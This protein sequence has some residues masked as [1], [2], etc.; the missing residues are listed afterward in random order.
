M[1]FLGAIL[2]GA[3]SGLV[4]GIMGGG[5]SKPGGSNVYSPAGLNA[6]DTGWQNM[7]SQQQNNAL[8]TQAVTNPLYNQTLAALTGYQFTPGQPQPIMQQGGNPLVNPT[9]P[10]SK[11]FAPQLSE[12]EGGWDNTMLNQQPGMQAGQ[13]AMQQ[14][15]AMQPVG[16]TWSQTGGGINY[17]PWL[18]SAQQAGQQYQGVA[19]LAGKQ[20]G[21]YGQQAGLA[22]RQ[23]QGLYD[24]GNQILNTAMD[25]RQAL[26]QRTQQQLADQVNAG[27]AMRGL[28]NSAVGGQEYNQAMSNFDIDWQNQQL[29]RQLVGIQG[30]GQASNAGGAQGQLMGAYLAGQMGSAQAQ[31]GFTQQAGQ[32]PISAQQYVAGQP[33]AAANQY[34]GNISNQ[35]QMLGS[36]GGQAIPYMYQ[37]AG[38]QQQQQLFNAQQNAAMAR[39]MGNIAQ[40]AINSYN[41]PGSWLNNMFNRGSNDQGVMDTSGYGGAFDTSGFNSGGFV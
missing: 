29:Q 36:V 26:F 15:S 25:P 21:I 12:G 11:Q 6:A 4:G 22:G 28:G 33:A 20:A 34:L 16:G 31:P 14:G 35:N 8:N 3:A 17:Q 1:P 40:S 2:G 19:D 23:Q 41:T 30:A 24:A 39:G 32:V 13:P 9:A 27:Q 7:F 18:Q 37:G 5:G 10:P 38:T